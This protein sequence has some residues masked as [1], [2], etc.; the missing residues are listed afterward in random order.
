MKHFSRWPVFLIASTVLIYGF[1]T[2]NRAFPIIPTPSWITPAAP[3]SLLL[4]Q[5][6]LWALLFPRLVAHEPQCEPIK[7]VNGGDL[8]VGYDA[9][10][11]TQRPDRLNVTETQVSALRTAHRAFKTHLEDMRYQLP[12]VNG[13]RGIV[14]TAGGNYLPVSVVSIRMLRE[15]GCMLPV[16]VFLACDDEWDAEICDNVF[17][18]MSARCVVLDSVF[19]PS[20]AV[21]IEKYQYKIMAIIFSSFQDVLFLDSDSFP[22]HDPSGLF[23]AEPFQSTGMVLWPDFW[24]ASE[25]PAF[26][27][28]AGLEMPPLARMPATESGELMYSKSKHTQS[29]LLA[30][31]YNFYG[32]DFYYPLQAQGAPGE[33]DKET[34]LWAA[35]AFNESF[36]KVQQKIR[37]LGYITTSK[38]W[39]GSAMVQYDPRTDLP[40]AA[41]SSDG[42]GDD[43]GRT[44]ARPLFVHANFPKLNPGSIFQDVSF[45]VTG[46]TRDADGTMRRIWHTSADEAVAFCGY[47][48]ERRLW[49]VVREIAC[50]YEGKFVTWEGR[51]DVCV[52]ATV[53][54]DRVFG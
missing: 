21:R 20:L 11:T 13:T 26:F 49:S 41:A 52:N 29:L 42:R 50:R 30:L 31:Y 38:E 5:Q 2:A 45:G 47:D 35:L 51:R 6:D 44:M 4:A 25:S 1:Y 28:I 46:P 48:A 18:S 32:P 14:T 40:R 39:R 16:E 8:V 36:H 37:A 3:S 33:G 17:P 15:T 53:Y 34:F 10:R 27:D 9:S 19:R 54:W 43:E 24:F 7:H 22:L 12:F 23:T